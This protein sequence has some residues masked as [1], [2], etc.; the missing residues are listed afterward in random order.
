M[1][2][3]VEVIQSVFNRGELSPRI[4]GRVDLDAYYN[5]LKYSENFIPFPQ[6]AVT[7][8]TG[9]YYVSAVKDSADET[10]LIP[11]RF[12]TTQNYAIEVGDLYMRF[13]RNRGQVE[14]SPSVPYELTTPWPSSVLRELKYVQSYDRLYVFHKDYQPR[15]IT[16]TSDTSWTITT[17]T[18]IDG[19]FLPTNTTTTTVASSATTG[20]VTL[21]ASTA[22]FTSDYISR[23]IRIKS[24][25]TYGWATITGVTIPASTSIT[26]AANNGSGLIRITSATHG[27]STGQVVSISGVTGTAEANGTWTVTVI[28]ANTFDLQGST[29]TN[30]YVSGGTVSATKVLTASA[31]IGGT[32]GGTAA[33]STWAISY[34]GG[35][36][37]WPSVATIYEQRLIM[38]NTA[39]YPATIFASSTGAFSDSVTMSPS[40]TSGTVTDS[41][42]FVYTIGDDQ[43]NAIQWLSSGRILMIGTTGAEHSM[44][45]GT[46]SSYAPVT[47][48][49]VTIKR[50]AKIGSRQNVRAHRVGNAI[51]YVSGSGLKV[52]ELNY[53]FGIDSYVS[54][55][56]TIFN[57]HITESGIIDC[58][59]QNEP[60][61]TLWCARDDGKLIGFSYERTQQV[62]GWHRHS[63]GGTDAQV[64]SV[65]CIPK[66][67]NDGD[68]LWLIVS[69][70][71]NGSTVQTV[72]Y[73]YDYFNPDLYGKESAFFVD[74]GATYDGRLDATLTPSAASGSSVTFTAGSSVFTAG[75]VGSQIRYGLSRALITGYTSGTVVTCSISVAFPSTDVIDS[76]DWSVAVRTITGLSRL[77]AETVSVCA[78]GYYAGDATVSSGSFTLD[79]FASIIHAGLPY[80]SE[81]RTLPV[82]V[83]SM[84]TIAGRI[85]RTNLILFY[86]TNTI[87]LSIGNSLNSVIE[88]VPFGGAN[89]NL[90]EGPS[91]YNGV[92]KREP[93]IGFDEEGIIKISHGWPTNITINYIAQQLTIN[94]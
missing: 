88:V 77:E 34:F 47:P 61:P 6:G 57:D 64:K 41:D 53:D 10:I 20:S 91:V 80:T 51:L 1:G 46:S 84:G 5:A 22:I 23:Q 83:R 24:G 90:N 56:V 50:E 36:M 94:G 48:S 4:V 49:N 86:L 15:V 66:P 29:F 2:Q 13:Y 92:L 9:T 76:G 70:T 74:S 38:A 73:M 44:T 63:F 18:F 69:R 82:E 28:T 58:D 85:R 17:L 71:I 65:C 33:T 87:G 32:L 37:G 27:L 11:F 81:L 7:K 14:S 75:M 89:E 30:A 40:Q 72:E 25:S 62:E 3:N 54:R 55:D 45:G 59:F 8:R 26:G 21:T 52:R 68:D 19:P 43:V 35:V 42:G 16:R 31:T 67:D 60:D 12:S 79:D 39:L 93:P 78:D